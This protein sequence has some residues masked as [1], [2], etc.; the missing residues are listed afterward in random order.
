MMLVRVDRFAWGTVKSTRPMPHQ[1]TA[2]TENTLRGGGDGFPVDVSIAV[3]AHDAVETITF[4]MQ[5]IVDIG[6]PRERVTVYDVASTDGTVDWL[7]EHYPDIRVVRLKDNKGPNPARNRAVRDCGTPLVLVMD[8][9]VQLLPATVG[10]LH[11]AIGTHDRIAAA[12]P[13]VLYADRP[14]TV[15]YRRTWIHF[16]AEAS[17][18]IHDIPLT[19]LAGV[20]ERVGSASGCAPLFRKDA[21]VRAGLFEERYFFGKTDGEFAY[22][23]TTSGHDIVEPA[24]AQV[25]H[26]HR[27]KRGGK[28]YRHQLQNRWHFMCRDYQLRTLIAILPVL[29]IH[30]P[31]L[32]MLMVVMGHGGDYLRALGTFLA[33]LPALPAQRRQV[34]RVRRRHDWQVLRGDKLVIPGDIEDRP[35]FRQLAAVYRWA[36]GVYWRAARGVL[37]SISRPI[38]GGGMSIMDASLSGA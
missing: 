28:F 36:L 27:R 23:V 29:V 10:V 33:M 38:R 11:C 16:L 8:A 9:D 31:M 34:A 25:L 5:G 26:H 22:R 13:V 35:G 15:Q 17:A 3:I 14:E 37:R 1:T 4:C 30:E 2:T 6:C 19:G 24:E 7:G 18:D 20:T 12:T 21:A 32:F